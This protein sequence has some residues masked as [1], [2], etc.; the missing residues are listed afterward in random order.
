MSEVKGNQFVDINLA[1][2]KIAD[3]KIRDKAFVYIFVTRAMLLANCTGQK[4]DIQTYFRNT[5]NELHFV[6][7]QEDKDV[8]DIIGRMNGVTDVNTA[9][10]ILKGKLNLA[11]SNTGH[12]I[13]TERTKQAILNQFIGPES[14]R[15]LQLSN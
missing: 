10:E 1:L 7:H 11:L 13:D 2:A 6:H 5:V 14:M 8:K 9:V 15:I 3:D 12:E 4:P